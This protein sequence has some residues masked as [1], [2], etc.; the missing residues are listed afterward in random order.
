M[1]HYLI[2]RLKATSAVTD[3]TTAARIFPLVRLQG[4][5]VPALVLQLVGAEPIE[6]KDL[7]SP[8]DEHRVQITGLAVSPSV[9]WALMEAVRGSLEGWGADPVVETRF[10]THASDIFESSDLF[11]ITA[12]YEVRINRT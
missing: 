4:S 6:A 1:I 8:M 5:E 3:I 7:T 10:V 12:T 11:T 2:S 9:T